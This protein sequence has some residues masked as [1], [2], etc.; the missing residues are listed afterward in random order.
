M[1]KKNR[2]H[3]GQKKKYK[4]VVQGIRI[5]PNFEDIFDAS[6]AHRMH[7]LISNYKRYVCVCVCVCVCVHLIM[8]A[9]ESYYNIDLYC[10]CRIDAH[11]AQLLF[12]LYKIIVSLLLAM[13]GGISMHRC[14]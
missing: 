13:F 2:Q 9:F 8:V 3:N 1:S 10:C 14:I 5:T 6:S 12:C 4:R 11:L 7:A